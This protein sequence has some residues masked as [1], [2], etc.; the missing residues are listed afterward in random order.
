MTMIGKLPVVYATTILVPDGEVAEIAFAVEAWM[1]K[2]RL[3]FHPEAGL[4]QSAES[5][6]EGDA[7]RLRFNRWVNP[8]GTAYTQPVEAARSPSGQPIE[9]LIYQ[10]RIGKL[11]RVDLQFTVGAKS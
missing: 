7:L 8:L 3:S 1:F 5:V 10:H 2:M 6:V 4:E 9:F 11:N